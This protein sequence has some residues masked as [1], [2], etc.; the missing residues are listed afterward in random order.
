MGQAELE[1]VSTIDLIAEIKRRFGILNMPEKRVAVIGPPAVGK[2]ALS[3]QLRRSFGICQ[4]STE[5]VLA[6]GEPYL[7]HVA[8]KLAEPQCRRGFVLDDFPANEVGAAKLAEALD[9]LGK[10]LDDVVFLEAPD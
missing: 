3:T 6:Q 4:V 1:N 8:R 5:Q 2:T 9:T 7:S 10:P